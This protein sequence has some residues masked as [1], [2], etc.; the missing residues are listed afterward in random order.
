MDKDSSV[1]VG[2]LPEELADVVETYLESTKKGGGK[3]ESFVLDKARQ[4]ALVTFESSI[5]E[6]ICSVL[7]IHL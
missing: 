1:I 6:F 7:C 3:I 2:N 4:R 5:G